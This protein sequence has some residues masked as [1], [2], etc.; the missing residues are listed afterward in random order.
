MTFNNLKK[1]KLI[2][3]FMG[4]KYSMNLNNNEFVFKEPTQSI[5]LTNNK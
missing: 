2:Y 5:L 1:H 4:K 3:I